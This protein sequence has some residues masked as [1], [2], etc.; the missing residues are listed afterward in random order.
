M[1]GEFRRVPASLHGGVPPHHAAGKRWRS[2]PRTARRA[3]PRSIWTLGLGWPR[4]GYMEVS[5]HYGGASTCSRNGGDINLQEF[6]RV[7]RTVILSG[8]CGRNLGGHVAA[9]K[10]FARAA[11]PTPA[12]GMLVWNQ[13][14]PEACGATAAK[15]CSRFLRCSRSLS[16]EIQASLP[17]RL[18]LS[19][20]RRSSG[21]SG[22]TCTSSTARLRLSSARRSSVG[23]A[24]TEGERTE[25]DASYWRRD[26]RGLG[27]TELECATPRRRSTSSR[28]CLIAPGEAMELGGW[29]NNS[30]AVES[31]L[32][33]GT[34]DGV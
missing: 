29:R 1:P 2:L 9:R 26:D 23:A 31:A 24:L 5:C 20:S 25:A 32:V 12:N 17:A 10:W 11:Q 21:L 16:K 8:R 19:S 13:A 7:C 4:Q 18:W 14:S 34:P 30:L 6:R 28:H 27:L 3:L 33:G 22:G 15:P